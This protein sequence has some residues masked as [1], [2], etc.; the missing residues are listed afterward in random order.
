MEVAFGG[1][2]G[3]G[4]SHAMLAQMGLDDCQRRAGL[5]CLLLRRVGKAVRESMEDLRGRVLAHCLHKYNRTSGTLTFRNGSRIILGHFKDE[6]DIDNYL[7]L[8][9]DVIGT[10]E[11]TTLPL[12]RIKAIRTCN[13]TSMAGWRPRMYYNANPGGIGHNWFK[14][15]FVIETGQ[16]RFIAATYRDNKFLDPWYESKLNDLTGW[17][18]RAW[19]DGDWDV[20]AGT[21]FTNFVPKVHVVDPFRVDR[22]GW[23]FYLA[24]DYGWTHPNVFLLF[25]RDNQSSLYFIDGYA[26]SRRLP[27]AHHNKILELLSRWQ[28]RPA[29]IRSFVMGTDAWRPNEKGVT[30]AESYRALGWR[31]TQAKMARVQGAT[32]LLRRL[33]DIEADIEPTMRIFSTCQELIEQLPMLQHDGHHPEDV[34]KVDV[35]EDGF[36]GD[37]W[38]DAARYAVMS[39]TTRE[40]HYDPIWAPR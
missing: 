26:A 25:A 22:L 15:R 7:G 2:R 38:Y 21:Y 35:D 40:A 20:H 34:L 31:P 39:M 10:E 13:R 11:A 12:S 36:G 23:T 24:M 33:G 3:P 19:K 9:Y 28:L 18:R 16:P 6:R 37:D 14:H 1:A 5:K 8:E 29:D 17:L 27:A 4:K 30:V 32:E